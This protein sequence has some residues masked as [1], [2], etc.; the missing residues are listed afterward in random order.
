MFRRA[1]LPLQL[2]GRL[3]AMRGRRRGGLVC[4]GRGQG[5]CARHVALH[6]AARVLGIVGF[7]VRCSVVSGVLAAVHLAVVRGSIFLCFCATMRGVTI[8][9][10]LR[11]FAGAL[12]CGMVV[13]VVPG[14]NR[15]R[16]GARQD[17]HGQQEQANDFGFVTNHHGR[18]ISPSPAR[19]SRIRPIVT[20]PGALWPLRPIASH[21]PA[22]VAVRLRNAVPVCRCWLPEWR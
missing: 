3:C 10:R 13:C 22:G 7:L 19:C 21:L 17:A 15:L 14:G 11:N 2:R 1:R 6:L 9:R 12:I 20:A 18:I 8:R 16:K 5:G 4:I